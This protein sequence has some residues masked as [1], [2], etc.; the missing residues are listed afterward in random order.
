M[1]RIRHTPQDLGIVFNLVRGPPETGRLTSP[2][3]AATFRPCEGDPF[4]GRGMNT[5]SLGAPAEAP[6]SGSPPAT[7]GRT[8]QSPASARPIS[9]YPGQRLALRVLS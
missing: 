3:F 7:G 4:A 9:P 6:A 5:L 1:L 8:G 2:S